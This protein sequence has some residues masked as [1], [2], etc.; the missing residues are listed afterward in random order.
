MSSSPN[1]PGAT[2]ALPGV[3][4]TVNVQGSGATIVG[5]SRIV[6][7]IGQGSTTE[8]VVS[9]AQGG[10][11]DGLIV[12]GNLNRVRDSGLQLDVIDNL[13]FRFVHHL[14]RVRPGADEQRSLR[15]CGNRR[16]CHREQYF[17]VKTQ[18]KTKSTLRQSLVAD[19]H[20][21]VQSG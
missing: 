13:L 9:S 16:R 1:I 17:H 18:G 20:F 6:A 14:N 11:V 4:S 2:N 5:G 12:V 3:F 19:A 8:T 15:G 10:G 21:A 7:M